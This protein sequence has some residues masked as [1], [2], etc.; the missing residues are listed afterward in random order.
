MVYK[1]SFVLNPNSTLLYL[2]SEKKIM[3]QL[4]NNPYILVLSLVSQTF[5]IVCIWGMA[6]NV[7]YLCPYTSRVQC[8]G[9]TFMLGLLSL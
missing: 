9:N 8:Q 7:N 2:V 6:E 4:E 1:K 5:H 3:L